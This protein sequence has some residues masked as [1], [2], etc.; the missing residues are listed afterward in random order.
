MM[1]LRSPLV[2]QEASSVTGVDLPAEAAP[3][4][5][6]LPRASEVETRDVVL[7]CSSSVL[8]AYFLGAAFEVS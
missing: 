5:G 7:E 1:F 8:C 6:V 2:A 3:L 4:G